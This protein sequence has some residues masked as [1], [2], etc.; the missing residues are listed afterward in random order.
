MGTPS[1]KSTL[2]VRIT[3]SLADEV[4]QIA[5]QEDESFACILRRLIRRGLQAERQRIAE[6]PR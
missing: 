6:L 4:R 3:D 5:E 1:T 2:P